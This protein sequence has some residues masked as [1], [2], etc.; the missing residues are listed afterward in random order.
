[1]DGFGCVSGHTI[2]SGP[3]GIYY[4]SHDGVYLLGSSMDVQL[5]SR[6][7]R[8]LF[9]ELVKQRQIYATGVYD[10]RTSRYIL[11]FEGAD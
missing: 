3:G 1:V 6:S 4:L 9:A 7:Q 2:S 5:V 8:P 10:H 11:S